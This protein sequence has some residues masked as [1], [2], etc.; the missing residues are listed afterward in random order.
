M[1]KLAIAI[2]HKKASITIMHSKVVDL[3]YAYKS[4]QLQSCVQKASAVIV[5]L[6]MSIATMNSFKYNCAYNNC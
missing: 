6:S 5:Q 3:N 1:E 2:L 4:C